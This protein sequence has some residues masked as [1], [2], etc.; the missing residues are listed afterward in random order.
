MAR[1]AKRNSA[2]KKRFKV[3]GKSRIKRAK[4]FRRHLLSR[5]SAK[6]KRNL[7]RRAYVSASDVHR[8]AGLLR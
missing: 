1:K 3:V 4:A 6:R 2:A 7:R 8:I 5:K